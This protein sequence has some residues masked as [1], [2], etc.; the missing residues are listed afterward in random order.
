MAICNPLPVLRPLLRG[1]NVAGASGMSD[2]D[3]AD[4]FLPKSG[5]SLRAHTLRTKEHA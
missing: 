3:P 4:T 2:V 1:M 5:L